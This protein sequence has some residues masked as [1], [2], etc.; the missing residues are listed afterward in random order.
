[1]EN[2]DIIQAIFRQKRKTSGLSIVNN[3][4][5]VLAKIIY[6]SNQ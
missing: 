2:R 4:K 3:N 1:M 5:N 6:D